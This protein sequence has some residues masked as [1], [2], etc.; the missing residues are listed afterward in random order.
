MDSNVRG[1]PIYDVIMQPRSALYCRKVT[2]H[3]T[4]DFRYNADQYHT[5]SFFYTDIK[6]RN[7]QMAYI[8]MHTYP[9]RSIFEQT[10]AHFCNIWMAG[11]EI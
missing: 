6:D 7:L 9:S 11:I 3:H 8:Y 2:R 10:C 5:V 4:R 1:V